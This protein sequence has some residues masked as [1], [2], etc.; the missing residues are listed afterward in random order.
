MTMQRNLPVIVVAAVAC[1]ALAVAR[2]ADTPASAGATS[3]VAAKELTP[4]QFEALP[5]AASID[6][7]GQRMTKA[8]F[9]A[10]RET[11]IRKAFD[12]MKAKLIRAPAEF[13]DQR[14]SFLDAERTKLDV[15]NQ[16]VAAE[17]EQLRA[18]DAALHG[19]N[20]DT[21]R[22]QATALMTQAASIADPL[23]RSR[24]E[25]Q[26]ADLLTPRRP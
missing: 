11:A 17:L 1:S 7:D 26:A 10:Q 20:W 23:E 4:Q 5:A 14:K 18:A 12:D 15:A 2:A 22:A 6:V 13:A 25:R 24:L 16:K 21:R 3:A 8:E 19:D 9:Q